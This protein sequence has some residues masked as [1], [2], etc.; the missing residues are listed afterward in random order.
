MRRLLLCCFALPLFSLIA[1]GVEPLALQDPAG[2]PQPNDAQPSELR[3]D[4]GFQSSWALDHGRAYAARFDEG[5]SYGVAEKA[6]RPILINL[7]YP[8][9]SAASGSRMTHEDYFAIAPRRP[10]TSGAEL[11][12]F[13]RALSDYARAVCVAEVFEE[14]AGGGG[15]LHPPFLDPVG[16][17]RGAEPAPGPFP[18]VVYHSGAGSSFEDNARLC[19]RLARCGYVVLGSAFPR[20]DG[21][22]LGV[23][24]RA[25]SIDDI[26]FLVRFAEQLDF[27]DWRHIAVAGHSL[28]AQ[29]VLRYASRPDCVADA[30]VLLDTTQ[31]YYA[32]SIP[33]YVDLVDE[34]MAGVESVSQPVLVAAGPEAMFQLCDRLRRAERFYL[35]VPI[36]GHNEFISQGIQRLEAL[37]RRALGA[38]SADPELQHELDRAQVVR[39][40]YEELCETVVLFLDAYLREDQA[41]FQDR[42][43]AYGETV[44]GGDAL[45]LERAAPGASGPTPYDRESAA[46]PTPRQL[47]RLLR[48]QGVAS[49]LEVLE[50]FSSHEPKT[51]I[52]SS[53]MIMGSLLYE[54]TSLDRVDDARLLLEG[55]R[56]YEPAALSLFPFLASMSEWGGKTERALHYLRYANA[57]DPL[58]AGIRER[59]EAI[60]KRAKDTAE[61]E[62]DTSD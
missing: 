62:S 31:D 10:D 29:A 47:P 15:E 6:P 4:A 41:G 18:L 51:P 35:T 33:T 30:V 56:K 48:E 21:S 1:W 9:S 38:S 53:T 57:L 17:Y 12:S 58:D 37:E 46:P 60:E 3:Y 27:V 32:L 54:L 25:G 26:R 59:L 55:F 8:S 13:A 16:V 14:E 20:A 39:A 7:W 61:P 22:S 28:G 43:R 49:T 45:H 2:A 24:G 40:R 44:L 19:E 23:D 42:A 34:V 5:A 50:R 11:A 36:V 52:Y